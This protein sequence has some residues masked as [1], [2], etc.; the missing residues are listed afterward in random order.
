MGWDEG[1]VQTLYVDG[2]ATHVVM[3]VADFG[4]LMGAQED[5]LVRGALERMGRREGAVRECSVHE[6][7]EARRSRGM[8]QRELGEKV[9]IPQSQVSRMERNA[10]RCGVGTLEKV[11]RVLGVRLVIGE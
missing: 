10:S 1:R 5:P 2:V 4:V 8:S 11:A 6:V 3:R 9:G 7:G